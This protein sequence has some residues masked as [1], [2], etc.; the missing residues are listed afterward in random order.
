MESF[1]ALQLICISYLRSVY[2]KYI[3]INELAFYRRKPKTVRFPTTGSK[4]IYVFS[5]HLPVISDISIE[6]CLC[7]FINL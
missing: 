7:V 3:I 4:Q 1:I 6:R 5:I 2:W